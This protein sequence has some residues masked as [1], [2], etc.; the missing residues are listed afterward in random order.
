[1]FIGISS[2]PPALLWFLLGISCFVLEL[3]LPGLLL[4]F[5]GIGAWCAAL[6]VLLMP[7][8][9][10]LQILI[11]LSTS[12]ITLVLLR[13][14]FQKMFKGTALEIDVGDDFVPAGAMAEV[15]EDI[16]PPAAG[17][18]KYGGT[19]W[20]AVSDEPVARGSRVR[21]LAKNNLSLTVEAV[22]AQGES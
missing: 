6:A 15:V 13:A 16:V 3:L 8:P 14:K 22:T 21:V 19:F 5:F 11:F 18:V 2:V 17:K 10:S 20:Q 4:F 12:I 1:M 9:L 7:M